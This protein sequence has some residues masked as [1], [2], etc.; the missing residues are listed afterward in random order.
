MRTWQ[1]RKLSLEAK[2][3]SRPLYIHHSADEQSNVT[4]AEK[5]WWFQPKRTV[6]VT[7]NG[8]F[9]GSPMKF[10]GKLVNPDNSGGVCA[11]TYTI[12][13]L[14]GQDK[15]LDGLLVPIGAKSNIARP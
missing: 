13:T 3:L 15:K 11:G 9:L 2:E 4:Y 1:R 8:A 14:M 5:G 12:N 7:S 10:D 6:N